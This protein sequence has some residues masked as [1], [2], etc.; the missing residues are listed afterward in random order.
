MHC[1]DKYLASHLRKT[2]LLTGVLFFVAAVLFCRPV[3]AEQIKALDLRGQL[4]ALADVS[5]GSGA[6]VSVS[7]RGDAT[8]N[9]SV[10][11]L[12]AL[13]RQEK[14]TAVSDTAGLAFFPSVLP[15]TY[16]VE[17]KESKAEIDKV[18]LRDLTP[19][20]NQTT[21]NSSLASDSHV[22]AMYAGGAAAVA[23]VL[24]LGAALMAGGGS[25]SSSSTGFFGSE[26]TNAARNSLESVGASVAAPANIDPRIPFSVYDP[27]RPSS[28]SANPAPNP[29]NPAPK[30]PFSGWHEHPVPPSVV[31]PTP[32]LSPS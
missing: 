13:S 28:P 31:D 20:L 30:P 24:G 5:E 32:E 8:S 11:L 3:V 7:L 26:G 16:L 19:S 12:D 15:G 27:N 18:E 10:S 25:D 9:V 23:G 21:A 1:A 2:V 17:V 29:G 4:L 22:R 6:A 14:F